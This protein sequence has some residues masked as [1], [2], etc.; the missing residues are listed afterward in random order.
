MCPHS[1]L[2]IAAHTSSG[3]ALPVTEVLRTRYA[4]D[5]PFSP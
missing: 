2:M 1:D 5:K 4:R 3:R